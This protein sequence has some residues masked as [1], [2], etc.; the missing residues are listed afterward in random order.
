MLAE[1]ESIAETAYRLG[2][3]NVCNFSRAYR[4]YTGV[5][6]SAITYLPLENQ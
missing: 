6:P 1:G 5:P 3:N 4:R 2:Y